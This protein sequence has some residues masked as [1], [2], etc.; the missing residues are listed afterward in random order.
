MSLFNPKL[1]ILNHIKK[2]LKE[3]REKNKNKP[4][5][6]KEEIIDRNNINKILSEKEFERVLDKYLS[7]KQILYNRDLEEKKNSKKEF[8]FHKINFSFNEFTRSRNTNN[9]L[10]IKNGII[11]K[12]NNLFKLK[13]DSTFEK[14]WKKLSPKN[15]KKFDDE[16]NHSKDKSDI[17]LRKIKKE[18]EKINSMI[19]LGVNSFKAM[20]GNEIFT[21]TN[22]KIENNKENNHIKC[23]IKRN[24]INNLNDNIT[25]N[26]NIIKLRNSYRNKTFNNMKNEINILRMSDVS[27]KNGKVRSFSEYSKNK[28]EKGIKLIKIKKINPSKKIINPFTKLLKVKSFEKM[29]QKILGKQKSYNEKNSRN[30]RNNISSIDSENQKT[31]ILQEYLNILKTT[32]EMRLNYLENNLIPS[33]KL[34]TIMKTREELMIYSLKIKL[35]KDKNKFFNN[36]ELKKIKADNFKERLLKSAEL[37]GDKMTND[38]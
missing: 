37:F 2:Q 12:T 26:I 15:Y 23:R 17:I 27:L 16:Y 29:K 14:I 32:K 9:D 7:L 3:K 8:K 5:Y 38:I 36:K 24:T 35:L 13:V 18:K 4:K 30:K 11:S 6:L 33:N 34:D 25:N 28:E 22:K 19:N 20:F 31:S 10:N 21:K 1:L